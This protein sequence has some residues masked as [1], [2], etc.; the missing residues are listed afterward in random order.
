MFMKFRSVKFNLSLCLS[1]SIAMTLLTAVTSCGKKDLT[2][3]IAAVPP[4]AT[5]ITVI[6]IDAIAEANGSALS[7]SKDTS[8]P[9]EMESALGMF[10]PGSLLRPM[11]AVLAS[12]P[13]SVDTREIV[14]FTAS[15]G[16][17]GAILKV[18]DQNRL[19]EGSLHKLRD[20]SRDF[21]DYEVYTTGRPV[22]ALS[23]TICI[24]APDIATVKTVGQGSGKEKITDIPGV[25]EFLKGDN[26]VKNISRAS[27][28]F[29]SAMKGLWG[30]TSLRF[31][32]SSAIADLIVL[33]S[34]GEVDPVGTRIAGEIDPA[35]LRLIP[36]GCSL[37]AASGL[38]GEYT[39][40]TG[41]DRLI[42]SYLHGDVSMSKSGTTAWYARPAGRITSDNLMSPQV[43]NFAGIMQMSPEDGEQAIRNIQ[44]YTGGSP[45]LDPA[46]GCYIHDRGDGGSLSY[47]YLDGCF[48]Q[49][50]NGP[51][52]SSPQN[53]AG[54]IPPGTRLAVMID[55]PE[56]SSLQKAS[57]IPC[58]ATF[59]LKV[60]ADMI[61]AKL[62]FYGNRQPVLS[63]IFSIPALRE[64]L[65]RMAMPGE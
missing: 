33:R 51:V 48:I 55:I 11:G 10:L 6:D 13:E 47:G 62:S 1:V 54:T 9:A 29:G 45:V 32:T 42:G 18:K 5:S 2:D 61:H 23:E 26:A 28:I 14:V 64:A 30:C 46:S 31:N 65:S 35:V 50:V 56:G 58:G 21:G 3:P 38:K 57:G 36:Q 39:S 22:I 60:S 15:N 16:Y 7:G 27:D 59:D 53:A 49:S 41:I 19:S 34:D 44:I 37:V 24:I 63:T 43:W 40:K 20:K 8:I 17:T 4:G 25:M 12:S 52:A